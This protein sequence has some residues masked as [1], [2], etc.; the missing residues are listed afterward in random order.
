MSS[1]PS[2]DSSAPR[3]WREPV[4]IRAL[5]PALRARARQVWFW[6]GVGLVIRI[7]LLPLFAS[8][9]LLSTAYIT[10]LL[11]DKHQLILTNDPPP[12]YFVSGALQWLVQPLIPSNLSALFTSGASYTPGTTPEALAA[13]TGG[14]NILIAVLKLPYLAA[15]LVVALVLPRFFR[16]DRQAFAALLLWWFNPISIYVSYFVGQYD[17]VAT[18]LL[19]LAF[20]FLRS[21][22]NLECLIAIAAAT[23]FEGYALLVIPF[24]LIYWIRTSD[25]RIQVAKRV[26]GSLVAPAIAIGALILIFH[27]QA[28]YYQPA[29]LALPQSSI[30]G[31]YGTTIYNRGLAM[32]PLLAGLWTFVGFSAQFPISTSLSDVILVVVL[33][34]GLLLFLLDRVAK[35]GWDSIWAVTLAS[36]LV[37]Y[38]LSGFLVQ[39]VLWCLPL[40]TILLARN[41][42]SLILP[43]V[44]FVIGYFVYTWYFGAVLFGNLLQPSFPSVAGANPIATL[45]SIGLPAILVI[46]VG[47]S[48]FSAASLWFAY[49]ALRGILGKT[50]PPDLGAQAAPAS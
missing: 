36:F 14:I 15:D 39:W 43:Y 10:T 5:A 49:T 50:T 9:D 16:N 40:L 45:N 30:S 7:V 37:F 20:Y 3:A 18:A 13:Q 38:A 29:N 42:R 34:Y 23:F 35:Q 28:S 8:V 44:V 2:P 25:T 21:G 32:Q 12:I 22:R 19:L 27:F 46:N 33:A 24:L 17:I 26:V 11:I 4:W 47:R 1:P 48:L 31:N 6:I 41:L